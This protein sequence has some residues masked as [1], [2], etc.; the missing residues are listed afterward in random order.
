MVTTPEGADLLAA[1]KRAGNILRIEE[2]K[3][4]PHTGAVSAALLEAPE[5]AALN[6][7]LD[8]A[9]ASAK[10]A[11]AAED[12]AAAMAAL[13]TLRAPLDAFFDKVVVNAENPAIRVN[14][15]ALLN[16]VRAAMASVADLA[17]IEA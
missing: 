17:K 14:R 12:F 6:A 7:A 10:T 5:E 11:L 13:A 9:E 2:K 4:G 3:D 16:R 8:A 1:V 15:L